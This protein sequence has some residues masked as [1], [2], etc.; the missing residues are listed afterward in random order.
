MGVWEWQRNRRLGWIERET[1]EKM[2]EETATVTET[3][4][5][6]IGESRDRGERER[7]REGAE[8]E[9]ETDSGIVRWGTEGGERNRQWHSQVGDREEREILSRHKK[10]EERKRKAY[11]TLLKTFPPDNKDRT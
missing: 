8:G 9:R 1:K 7:E 10:A 2:E 11:S 3:Y 5:R 4:G 6:G